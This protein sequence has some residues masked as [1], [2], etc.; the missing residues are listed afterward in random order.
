M[1]LLAAKTVVTDFGTGW[2]AETEARLTVGLACIV[3]AGAG[4]SSATFSNQGAKDDVPA[5]IG[6]TANT[7]GRSLA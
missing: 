7:E 6:S 2:R 5:T 4:M 3:R 1:V